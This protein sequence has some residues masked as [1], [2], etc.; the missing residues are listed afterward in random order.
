[1]RRARFSLSALA[2]VGVWLVC[3]FAAAPGQAANEA[4]KVEDAARSEIT[5]SRAALIEILRQLD[6]AELDDVLQSQL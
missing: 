6:T 3:C 2:A 5:V 1:M 4:V